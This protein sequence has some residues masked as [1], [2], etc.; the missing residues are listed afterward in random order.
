MPQGQAYQIPIEFIVST[1]P[2]R[3]VLDLSNIPEWKVK[4][5]TIGF[6][7]SAGTNIVL[8]T[9][10]FS[11]S[12][13]V[14]MLM[15]PLKSFFTLDQARAYSINFLWGPLMTYSQDQYDAL[16]TTM[17]PQADSWN[18]VL[19]VAIII[20]L[21]W[22]LWRKRQTGRKA[23]VVFFL[24]FAFLWIVYDARMGAEIIGYAQK[25]V[26]TWW[27]QPYELKDYRDR[28][29]FAAFA[30]LVQEYTE[31]KDA[32]AFLASHGWPYWSTIQ[33]STYPAL[34]RTLEDVDES[35][36]TWIIY[37]RNDITIDASNR[38]SLDNKPI[39]P[40]GKVMLNF[41][42]GSF[43]FITSP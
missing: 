9:V 16:L 29:S 18:R 1:V 20:A 37:N 6:V 43:V 5:D 8:Q 4:T 40:P 39:S 10:E 15:Y 17:P 36:D 41:E 34:P 3:M 32:Y 25:D 19:Y 2:Q 14:D 27:S 42:P 11:G 30:D 13:S 26:Q 21:L 23:V 12:S 7:I 31:G 22:T 24:F 38:L 28:G 33:Y 35:I